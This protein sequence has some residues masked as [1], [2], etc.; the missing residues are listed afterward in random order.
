MEE[1]KNL[2]Y[3]DDEIEA[4]PTNFLGKTVH[5]LAQEKLNFRDEQLRARQI[6]EGQVRTPQPEPAAEEDIAL[7]WGQDEEGRPLAEK[8]FHP[9]V[10]KALKSLAKKQRDETKGFREELAKRDQREEQRELNRSAA[11]WD[12]AFAALGPEYEIVVGKGAG[13]EMGQAQQ[14]EYDN[15]I[16]ILNRAQADPRQHTAA[17][18]KAKVKAAAEKM[19]GKFLGKNPAPYAEVG[20]PGAT[21]KPAAPA[22][23]TNGVKP[24]ISEKEWEEAALARPTQRTHSEQKGEELAVKNL[25]ARLE[26][27]TIPDSEE[28]DGFPE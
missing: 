12:A 7:D 13:R 2:G 23:A 20:K 22:A 27:E 4:T 21:P 15:R 8:D 16:A 9:G 24:R 14:D 11:V 3:T 28:L 18:V 17:Q 19:F 1:A 26:S 5:R 25:A 6:S 10:V